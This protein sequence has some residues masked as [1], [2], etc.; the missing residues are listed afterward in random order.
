M[1][2]NNTVTVITESRNLRAL[3]FRLSEDQLTVG[4]DWKNWLEE[5]EREFRYFKITSALDKKRCN[6]Y[7]WG[8][9]N[10]TAREKPFQIQRILNV[11]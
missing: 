10:S 2:E 1:S 5:I 7:L 9:G 4:K 8:T 3:P 6:N 11:N